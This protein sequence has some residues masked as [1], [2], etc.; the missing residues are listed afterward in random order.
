MGRKSGSFNPLPFHALPS[1]TTV[2]INND[3][4]ITEMTTQF[5]G[6]GFT[7]FF[8][9]DQQKRLS[10]ARREDASNGIEYV[11]TF[12]YSTGN[13]SVDSISLELSVTANN[14]QAKQTGFFKK[15]NA[16]T[17][18]SIFPF[19]KTQAYTLMDSYFDATSAF[20]ESKNDLNKW[21]HTLTRQDMSWGEINWHVETKVRRSEN[22][23]QALQFRTDDD[24]VFHG[25]Y[26]VYGD[27]SMYYSNGSAPIDNS[28]TSNPKYLNGGVGYFIFLAEYFPDPYLLNEVFYLVDKSK[29]VENQSYATYEIN[30]RYD[31]KE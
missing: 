24:I 23:I 29:R 9:Y 6:S 17:Y 2:V 10:K 19:D 13:A 25:T 15:A 27:V 18:V 20:S 5:D 14:Q 8:E 11:A 31:W 1:R 12:F 16:S 4:R 30:A 3:K 28:N 26:E 7:D 22:E 21:F